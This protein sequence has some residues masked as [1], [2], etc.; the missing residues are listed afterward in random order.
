[1]EKCKDCKW[2]KETRRNEHS[3]TTWIYGECRA[4]PKKE[5]EKYPERFHLNDCCSLFKPTNKSGGI[6]EDEVTP[7]IFE[8]IEENM[9]RGHKKRERKQR[10]KETILPRTYQR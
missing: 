10:D 6:K 8:R 9:E 4:L 1:M 2:F 5:G 3:C 7:E